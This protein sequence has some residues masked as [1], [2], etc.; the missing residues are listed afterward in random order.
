MS[1]SISPTNNTS[2]IPDLK[3]T[4]IKKIVRRVLTKSSK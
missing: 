3:I 4:K 2:Q 1:E